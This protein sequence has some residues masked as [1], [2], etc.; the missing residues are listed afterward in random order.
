M[1]EWTNDPRSYRPATSHC[2]QL[3]SNRNLTTGDGIEKL[4]RAIEPGALVFRAISGAILCALT[5][6]VT[7]ACASHS[8]LTA[9]TVAP[10][11]SAAI[12]TPASGIKRECIGISGGE[13]RRAKSRRS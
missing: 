3:V 11:T 8:A 6:I 10:T 2:L 5:L 4:P 9:A 1:R 13:S 7:V 12:S